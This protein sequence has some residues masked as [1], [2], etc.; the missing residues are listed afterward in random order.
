MSVVKGLINAIRV[1]PRRLAV[2]TL[3]GATGVVVMNMLGTVCPPVAQLVKV[4]S[5]FYSKWGSVRFVRRVS[6]VDEC[7]EQR[8]LCT[9]GIEECVNTLGSYSCSCL[10]GYEHKVDQNSCG[11]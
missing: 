9:E 8:G 10:K 3:K 7:N 1:D 4:Y 5:A 11:G 6:D 2:S